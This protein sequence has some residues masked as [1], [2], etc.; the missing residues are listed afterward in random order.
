MKPQEKD[1]TSHVAYTRAL[2]EYCV[3]L[4]K[5]AQQALDFAHLMWADGG[6]ND[7]LK[8]KREALELALRKELGH[9]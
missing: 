5:A 3:G 2:E 8:E 6:L 7:Y 4:E 1:F 9:V